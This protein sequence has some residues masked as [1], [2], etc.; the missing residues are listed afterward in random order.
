MS[1]CKTFSEKSLTLILIG[2]SSRLGFEVFAVCALCV[3][4]SVNACICVLFVYCPCIRFHVPVCLCVCVSVR[5]CAL[6]LVS[7]CVSI[8]VCR[9]LS[10]CVCVSG[11]LC[12]VCLFICVCV[13]VCVCL[14]VSLCLCVCMSVCLWICLCVYLLCVSASLCFCVSV[15]LLCVCLS[16]CLSVCL[17]ICESV[18]LCFICLLVILCVC[19]C[20]SMCLYCVY[21]VAV[22]LCVSASF[23]FAMLTDARTHTHTSRQSLWDSNWFECKMNHD[24]FIFFS[25]WLN[26]SI[27]WGNSGRS[28]WLIVLLFDRCSFCRF[29]SLDRFSVDPLVV[30][31]QSLLLF[32]FEK[33]STPHH[34][35]THTHTRTPTHSPSREYFSP[36][37]GWFCRFGQNEK[38]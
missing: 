38:K 21:R 13:C 4:V 1:I 9:C 3:W 23:F 26:C 32:N 35:H 20:M 19:A 11:F 28:P 12:F 29:G 18:Y 6:C 25:R 15:Y 16:S 10:V 31:W 5:L 30:W 14:C 34:T 7:I 17:N 37:F 36:S 2:G 22:S 33:P 27:C 8:S 24:N